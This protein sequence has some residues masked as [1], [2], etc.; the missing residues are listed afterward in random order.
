MPDPIPSFEDLVEAGARV[1][2][3]E[4]GD[5]D[6]YWSLYASDVRAILNAVLPLVLA[7]AEKA[8]EPFAVSSTF[9][10]ERYLD[11]DAIYNA[12]RR[13][14]YAR[15]EVGHLRRAR[16]ILAGIKALVGPLPTDRKDNGDG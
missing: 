1:F 14:E 12:S 7:G 3:I 6:L 11:T 4:S 10:A 15:I 9:F 8:L 16:T 2:A 13:G 5:T